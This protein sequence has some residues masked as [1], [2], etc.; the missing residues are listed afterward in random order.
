MRNAS[1]SANDLPIAARRHALVRE[2]DRQ[3]ARCG[4]TFS[5][6]SAEPTSSSAPLVVAVSGGPDSTALLLACLALRLRRKRE[7]A[8][9]TVIA[10]H[11]HHH[12]RDA[13]DDDARHVT[14]L[15]ERFGVPL[16]IKHVQPGELKGNVSANAR[17]LRYQALA[18]V[19]RSVGAEHIAVAH[20]AEDQLETMIMAMCRGAGARG[21][22]AM[23]SAR[24]MGDV[25]IVRPLLGVLKRDCEEMCRRAGVEWRDDST[26]RDVSRRRARLRRDV[27]P[28]LEE[29]WPGAARRAAKCAM[30]VAQ[31][32][33][34]LPSPRSRE[35]ER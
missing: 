30:I 20:H 10:A 12:L 24:R 8:R 9:M 35:V 33:D 19:A 25:T 7:S 15:C 34:T 1:R 6:Q 3:L 28:I 18:E 23:R 4:L 5:A 11:V 2:V 32:A 14:D 27:T 21:L 13:A 29:L 22:A 31:L 16:H 26:N 17:R